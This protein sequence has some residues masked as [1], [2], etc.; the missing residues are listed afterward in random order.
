MAAGDCGG[1]RFLDGLG[2]WDATDRRNGNRDRS[3]RHAP[4]EQSEHQR[5]DCLPFAE[6]TLDDYA[7]RPE[8][9]FTLASYR[10][11]ITMSRERVSIV[12]KRVPR[13][14]S[15]VARGTSHLHL[16]G[17]SMHRCPSQESLSLT[18]DTVMLL[19][20]TS[21]MHD[22]SLIIHSRDIRC[23]E[24]LMVRNH[25]VTLVTRDREDDGPMRQ[26]ELM[27][28]CDRKH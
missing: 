20:G 16:Q 2:V 24:L 28:C 13:S 3:T 27:G 22:R 21:C 12:A 15:E 1:L 23:C 7:M 9:H 19:C 17:H 8:A 14:A 25:D 5:R 18:C 6:V 10:Q 11:R 4:D 26:T